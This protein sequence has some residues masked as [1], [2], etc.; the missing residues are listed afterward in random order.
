MTRRISMTDELCEHM[1]RPS[2][3]STREILEQ[4]SI[5]NPRTWPALS[6]AMVGSMAGMRPQPSKKS[7]SE[8]LTLTGLFASPLPEGPSFEK[9]FRPET[10]P[11]CYVAARAAFAAGCRIS[12]RCYEDL[13][14]ERIRL[15][16]NFPHGSPRAPNFRCMH[17][18]PWALYI[19]YRCL[20]SE[21]GIAS[22]PEHFIYRIEGRALEESSWILSGRKVFPFKVFPPASPRGPLRIGLGLSLDQMYTALNR[23]AKRIGAWDLITNSMVRTALTRRALGIDLEPA[24][25]AGSGNG[26]MRRDTGRAITF[27]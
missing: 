13:N 17:V 1:E 20:K 11:D 26:A 2:G 21:W 15:T 5:E 24:G 6:Y 18:T 9:R 14:Q 22:L 12:I 19:I 8:I 23:S 3:M 25:N 7:V 4:F 27:Q 16:I 10:Y